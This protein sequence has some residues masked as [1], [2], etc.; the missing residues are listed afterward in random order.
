M[1]PVNRITILYDAACGLCTSARD[2]IGKQSR[3]VGIE[4]LAAGSPEA[5]RAFPQI[6]PGELAVVAD[7]GEVWLGN[8]AWIVCLWALRDYRN[9]A[10]RLTSPGLL[11]LS[12]EAFITVSR[13][14]LTLS[15]LLGLRDPLEMEHQLRRVAVPQ[16][17]TDPK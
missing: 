13:N 2:W 14:R 16:C 8:R 10:F 12:R 1:P 6:V 15:R 3:L 11:L 17:Q 5:R 4:F 9:L 7:T